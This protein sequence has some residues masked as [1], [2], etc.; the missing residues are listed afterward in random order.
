MSDLV[1]TGT[2]GAFGPIEVRVYEYGVLR[3]REWC[4]TPAEALRVVDVW[5]RDRGVHCEVLGVST[6]SPPAV[7]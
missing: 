7:R 3:A 1:E 5:S 4:A 2:S 6:W